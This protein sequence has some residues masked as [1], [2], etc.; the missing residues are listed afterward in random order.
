VLLARLFEDLI[1]SVKSLSLSPQPEI[2]VVHLGNTRQN[3]QN[4]YKSKQQP[5]A[6]VYFK[7]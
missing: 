5:Q 2:I 6:A 3:R 1:A 4:G 7:V